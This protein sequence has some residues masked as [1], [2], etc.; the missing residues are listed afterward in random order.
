[1]AWMVKPHNNEVLLRHQKSAQ[2]LKPKPSRHSKSTEGRKAHFFRI[3]QENDDTHLLHLLMSIMS[4]LQA[5][6]AS[7][8]LYFHSA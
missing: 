7:I 6:S 1:M 2:A 8:G 5:S 3:N 4:A